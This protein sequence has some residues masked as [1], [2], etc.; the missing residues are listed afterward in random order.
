MEWSYI[1]TNYD[2]QEND[3]REIVLKAM[4]PAINK[5]VAIT[6]IIKVGFFLSFK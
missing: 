4:G 1:L 6:E 2:I 3:G 5:A